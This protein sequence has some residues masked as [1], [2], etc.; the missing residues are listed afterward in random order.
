MYHL[1]VSWAVV[2]FDDDVIR[3]AAAAIP[4]SP[5]QLIEQTPY[6]MTVN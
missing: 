5:E 6:H 4:S 2:V 3:H 1:F